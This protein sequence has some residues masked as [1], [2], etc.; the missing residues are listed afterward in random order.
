MIIKLQEIFA[1]LMIER[2]KFEEIQ[3]VYNGGNIPGILAQQQIKVNQLSTKKEQL[4]LQVI[5]K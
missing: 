4:Q 3:R 5:G 2:D 1:S